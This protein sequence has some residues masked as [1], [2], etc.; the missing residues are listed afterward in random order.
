MDKRK[1]ADEVSG[2][3]FTSMNLQT[4]A[5]QTI[6]FTMLVQKKLTARLMRPFSF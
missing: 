3:Q 5:E 1:Q 6:C 4:L 2:H